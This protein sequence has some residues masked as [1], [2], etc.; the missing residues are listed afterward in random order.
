MT[1]KEAFDIFKLN[2]SVQDGVID[3]VKTYMHIQYKTQ[4]DLASYCGLSKQNISN[5][6][7][8]RQKLSVPMAYFF[9]HFAGLDFTNLIDILFNYSTDPEE[10]KK[11][12]DEEND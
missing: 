10:M 2:P 12:E 4:T 8:K 7:R 9:C 6:F 3:I 11:R 5:Y 1:E